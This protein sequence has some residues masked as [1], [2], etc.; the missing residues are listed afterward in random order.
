MTLRNVDDIITLLSSHEAQFLAARDR[1]A[2]FCTTY[3]SLTRTLAARVAPGLFQD[4]DWVERLACI[5]AGYYEDALQ[6]K[7]PKC[8]RI[9]FEAAAAGRSLVIQDVLLGMNAHINHDLALALAQ[10]GIEP[11]PSRHHD[12]TAINRILAEA[13]DAVQDRIASWYAPGLAKL[14]EAAGRLDEFK[15]L[16]STTLAREHAW[17][18]AVA[19][20][21]SRHDWERALV[22]RALDAGSRLVARAILSPNPVPGLLG[23]LRRFEQEKGWWTCLW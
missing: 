2:V 21:A 17:F 9:A 7:T 12:H 6:G 4:P 16:F 14:D 3:L 5:F 1:R 11:R 18:S 19:L 10:I 20:T 23:A 22:E 8:W 15:A 13:A